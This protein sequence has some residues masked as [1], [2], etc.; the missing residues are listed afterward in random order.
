M[1]QKKM[2][3]P[4]ILR[5][6]EERRRYRKRTTE[7]FRSSTS[8]KRKLSG[9]KRNK[10]LR[11]RAACVHTPSRGSA[12]GAGGPC[13]VLWSLSPELCGLRL[14]EHV[15]THKHTGT[16]S[17]TQGQQLLLDITPQTALEKA[18]LGSGSSESAL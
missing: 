11:D 1:T 14:T 3:L 15:A 5:Q 17:G 18:S 8:I 6:H 13:E 2:D 16:L 4:C 9:K 7:T 12:D 10:L